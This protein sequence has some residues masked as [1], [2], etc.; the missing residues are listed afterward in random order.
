MF[1]ILGQFDLSQANYIEIPHLSYAN[2]PLHYLKQ[3]EQT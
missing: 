3:L 2:T 1:H